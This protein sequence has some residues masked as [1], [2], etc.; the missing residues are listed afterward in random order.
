MKV[1]G[2]CRWYMFSKEMYMN[3]T[4]QPSGGVVPT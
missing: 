1:A 2:F 4:R 3:H